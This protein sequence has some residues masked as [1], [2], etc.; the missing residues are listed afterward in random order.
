MKLYFYKFSVN[1]Q[2]P[3][4]GGYNTNKDKNRYKKVGNEFKCFLPSLVTCLFCTVSPTRPYP[5]LLTS[6]LILPHPSGGHFCC[7]TLA[8]SEECCIWGMLY[9]VCAGLV[10]V[11]ITGEH[12]T[13]CGRL[14]SSLLVTPLSSPLLLLLLASASPPCD[15][16]LWCSVGKCGCV[17][18]GSRQWNTRASHRIKYLRRGNSLGVPP[19]RVVRWEHTNSH[20]LF[21][22]IQMSSCILLRIVEKGPFMD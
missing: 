10:R 11:G 21:A 7:Q 22:R 3:V 6:V 5:G 12:I 9:L 20:G 16:T 17:G 18:G 15:L 2:C 19:H 4:I 1:K 14:T 8:V 13:D